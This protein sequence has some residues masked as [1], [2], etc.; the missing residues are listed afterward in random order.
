MLFLLFP[1]VSE[2]QGLLQGISGFFD[3]NFTTSSTK[4]T[5]SSGNTVKTDSIG[6]N[7]RFSLA[8]NTQIF[9]N[10]NLSAGGLV[11]ETVSRTSIN[12]IN[13]KSTGV[14]F[15]PYI[16][17]MWNS[18]PFTF[19]VGYNRREEYAKSGDTPGLTNINDEYNAVIGWKPD[20][21]PSVD[22][23]LFRRNVYD[24]HRQF[25]DTTTDSV[26]LG[27]KYTYKNL[28]VRYQASYDDQELKLIGLETKD[29]TQTGKITYSDS[30]F[31]RR[32]SFNA[33][34]NITRQDITTTSA[35]K[36]GEVT[37]QAFPFAGLS[38]NFDIIP[39]LALHSVTLNSN[40]ALI[41]GNLTASAGIDIGLPPLGGDTT[42]RHMGLD[43]LNITEVNN[44]LVWVDR[45]LPLNIA[46]AFSWDIYTSS[47]NLTWNF[48]MTISPAPFGQF[49]NRFELDFPSVNTRYIKVVTR[50]LAPAVIGASSFPNIF[51]TELQTFIKRPVGDVKRTKTSNTSQFINVDAKTRILDIPLLYY[52][53]SYFYSRS[54]PSGLSQYTLSNGLSMNHRFNQ[55]FSGTA[56]VAREDSSQQGEK[57]WDYIYNA[58]LTATPLRTLTNTL[59]FSGRTGKTKEGSSNAESLYLNNTAQLYQG[60]DVYLSGGLNYA[61]KETGEKT[62]GSDINF[63]SNIVPHRTLSL[64]LNYSYTTSDQSGGGKPSVSTY[65][66]RGD[67]NVSFSP[68]RTLYLYGAWSILSQTNIKTSYLQNYALGWSPFPGGDLQFNF[69]FT[70]TVRSEDRAKERS[71]GPSLR[72]KITNRSTLDVSYQ[73]VKSSSVSQKSD[74][75]AF[76]TRLQVF[77]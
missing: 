19:G 53:L 2:A 46:N 67:F 15:R 55:V 14:N 23:L 30:F 51:I 68:L 65:T 16:N 62:N 33:T 72:W 12:G 9:P 32:V 48:Y 73:M 66:G 38:I 11:E 31:D 60:I 7:P 59:V 58:T 8:I 17:L 74:T 18:A 47:D 70:E 63:G 71:I 37:L 21:L 4:S 42:P 44:L 20:G 6:Y 52:D 75:N 25:Q 56:R 39:P 41:D 5:D 61:K 29:L 40:P 13:T 28:D 77:F 34:Y 35:G 43:L 22:I 10:I 64:T 45:E 57:Q 27:V 54:D 36:G 1:V 76:S 49:Q 26:L 50:P 3:L 24:K 69:G